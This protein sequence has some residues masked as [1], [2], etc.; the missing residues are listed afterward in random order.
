[1]SSGTVA[2]PSLP[3]D[4][5]LAAPPT[6]YE[7]YIDQR[8]RQTRR[9]V[10][11]VDI[12][13]GLATLAV[14][15]LLYLLAAALADHWLIVGG[16]GPWGRWLLWLGLVGA[17]GT[18]FAFHLLP[19]LMHRVNPVFAASTIE[20][21]RPSL[22]NSLINFLLLR[23]RR[24]EMAAPVYNAIE[25]RAA[26]DLS[27]VRI[28]TAV[29]RTHLV[30]LCCALAVVLAMFSLY[31][32]FSPKNPLRSAAR[33]LFPWSNVAAPTRVTIND[34]RPG[35][36][37]A[38]HGEFITVSAELAGLRDGEKP[39]LIYSTADGQSVDQAVP[40]TLPEGEYRYQC[41]LPPDKLGLQQDYKY[42]LSA[43]DCRTCGYLIKVWNAPA[44]VVDKVV[45][46]YPGYTGLADQTLERQGDLR[47]IEGTEATIHA[48]ANA[49][50]KPGTAELD[51]GC[52]GRRGVRMTA[53]GYKS[54]GSF[55]LRLNADDNTP[56]YDCYQLRFSD[57]QGREN[58]RPVRHRIEVV[59]DLPP[60]IQPI[61]PLEREVQV[62]EN[63]RLTIRVRAEDPDFALRRVTLRAVR[64]DN[65]SLSIPPLLEKRRPEKAVQGEFQGE[66]AFEPARL[67]LKAGD[68][69][70]YWAE[71]EDNKEPTANRSETE[72]R[73]I[74]V[75]GPEAQDGRQ[76]QE[77]AKGDRSSD[78]SKE[79]EP[80]NDPSDRRDD[81]DRQPQDQPPE[82]PAEKQPS[83]DESQSPNADRNDR[84]QEE[85]SGD[86]QDG[87]QGEQSDGKQ[88][89]DKQSDSGNQ[90]ENQQGEGEQDDRSGR[91]IHPEAEPGDAMQEILKD[92]QRQQKDQPPQD[93]SQAENQ[94]PGKQQEDKQQSDERQPTDN[95][96][97]G[98]E[99]SSGDKQEE[100]QSGEEQAGG[101][102]S[103]AE[104]SA[105]PESQQE[106]GGSEK[107]DGEESA[108]GEDATG[109]SE[110]ESQK[111][112]AD[113]ANGE[114][115]AGEP[116]ESRRKDQG[117]GE[118]DQSGSETG[119]S[120]RQ[121]TAD[122]KPGEQKPGRQ[123]TPG[124]GEKSDRETGSPLPQEEAQPSNK[125]RPDKAGEAPGERKED[126]AQ[127]PGMGKKES[128]AQSDTAG[129]RK[130]GGEKGGGQQSNQPG[131][132]GPGSN[133]PAD[134]GASQA[135]EQG[136]G[137][138]GSR[139]GDR[140]TS[141]APTG[142]EQK[143]PGAGRDA[144]GSEQKAG[145]DGRAP[146]GQQ[147]SDP[148]DSDRRGE[149][150]ENPDKSGIPTGEGQKS[151]GSGA[152]TGG[153]KPGKADPADSSG[154]S[155]DSADRANLDY[156]GRQT[157]LAL[158]HLRDQVA[159][160]KPELLERL[161]WTKDDAR[162]F[163]ARWEEMR[164]SAEEK[165]AAGETAR[166]RFDDA[167]K[168]LGLR[169]RGTELKRGGVETEKSETQRDA[170]R[171]AP[172]PDW[173]DQFRAYTRGISGG[174]RRDESSERK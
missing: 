25:Q 170:A 8:L 89:G 49:E 78:Q 51:F 103:G 86:K 85:S 157:A 50:I 72:K 21:S 10:K 42:H 33:V 115:G 95:R 61:E 77:G 74:V 22:R 134:E 167:L 91:R 88:Q 147:Q 80:S 69:V 99:Q 43:G 142:S 148:N 31:L 135:D 110:T 126:D 30:R 2:P 155:D 52:T 120:Q 28:E 96:E 13:V 46:R 133:T 104:Q 14:G 165:G 144:D 111:S 71:A 68:R 162:R 97:T 171:F 163:L 169:P 92:R 112:D 62:A 146:G 55:R 100:G 7:G 81:A 57:L 140:E 145:A 156:A 168:S 27:Q 161:G 56:E 151:E 113:K 60:E 116:S 66:Y 150:L 149:P 67:G 40:M 6:E 107:A 53:D 84:R 153:G 138:T 11:S 123:D 16:L 39:L 131:V 65:R 117:T 17:A 20:K 93:K 124:N 160:E 174:D 173:A 5:P 172:P 125:Q 109:Q 98:T 154:S 9:Q 119:E 54:A 58:T 18:F 48:T 76:R 44:I 139:A 122:Q 152:V 106:K 108:A 64:D 37:A 94:Q 114:K 87:E 35:D 34:V 136:E 4:V 23:G 90:G 158:E 59:R 75:A 24:R 73:W 70:Q 63:G 102:E 105:G 137:A 164:R 130:G 1:M 47:A 121:P 143:A 36:A 118:Q 26:A 29:D 45:Y 41:R 3:H 83:R 12:A 166:K 38:F 101:K 32:V 19:P 79:Q 132:G 15:A 128:D 82:D 127:S 141:K 129:D 159:K